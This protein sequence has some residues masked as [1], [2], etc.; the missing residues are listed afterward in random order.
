ML[1]YFTHLIYLIL[2]IDLADNV[3]IELSRSYPRCRF[4]CCGHI[5]LVI[6]VEVFSEVYLNRWV[7]Y[8]LGASFRLIARSIVQVGSRLTCHHTAEVLYTLLACVVV[9]R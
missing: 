9:L 8:K 2:N 6:N 3:R 5:C 7:S 1:L 4:Q